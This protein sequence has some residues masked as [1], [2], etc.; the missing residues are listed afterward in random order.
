MAQTARPISLSGSSIQSGRQCPK[1]LCLRMHQRKAVRWAVAAQDRYLHLIA[2]TT[3]SEVRKT[4]KRQ[5]LTYCE[6]DTLE[7]VRLAH[8]Q[9]S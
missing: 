6:L 4:L 1:C 7:M 3:P 2:A 9:S 8:W 5:L